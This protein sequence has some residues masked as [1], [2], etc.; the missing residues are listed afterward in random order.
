M[1]LLFWWLGDVCELQAG[2]WSN[3]LY[4]AEAAVGT[5]HAPASGQEANC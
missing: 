4:W 5:L 3:D 2:V 1:L